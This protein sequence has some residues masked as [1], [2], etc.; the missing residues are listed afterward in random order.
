MEADTI[1]NFVAFADCVFAD[2]SKTKENK[3]NAIK[4]TKIVLIWHWY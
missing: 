4:T 3:L 1:L 2:C